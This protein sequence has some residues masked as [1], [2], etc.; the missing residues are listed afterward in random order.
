VEEMADNKCSRLGL[1]ILGRCVSRAAFGGMVAAALLLVVFVGYAAALGVSQSRF[2]S[3]GTS[4]QPG[5]IVPAVPQAPQGSPVLP[6]GHPKIQGLPD[7]NVLPP[8]HPTV[9]GV[10]QAP[11]PKNAPKSGTLPP[12]HPKTVPGITGPVYTL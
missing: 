3:M 6:P 2:G 4:G 5:M 8:G 9:P 12:G 11:A 10:P 7:P 1:K